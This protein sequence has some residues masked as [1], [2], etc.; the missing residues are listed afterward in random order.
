MQCDGI[1]ERI[2]VTEVQAAGRAGTVSMAIASC[3]DEIVMQRTVFIPGSDTHAVAM[4]WSCRCRAY[5]HRS[6]ARGPVLFIP[7]IIGRSTPHSVCQDPGDQFS[8]SPISFILR[9]VSPADPGIYEVLYTD[10]RMALWTMKNARI[11]S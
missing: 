1:I 4:L 11:R 9:T 7:G 10:I 8:R 5:R 2:S 6:G 3:I